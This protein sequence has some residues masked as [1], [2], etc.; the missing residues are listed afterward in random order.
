[1]NRGMKKWT[2]YK[3]LIEQEKYIKQLHDNKSKL[4]RPIISNDIKEK[5]NNILSNYTKQLVKLKYYHNGQIFVI[6]SKINSIDVINKKILF[7]K[8]K[9]INFIDIIDLDII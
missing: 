2:P 6:I 3:S 4:E 8:N 7:S 9:C 5:I 1:M